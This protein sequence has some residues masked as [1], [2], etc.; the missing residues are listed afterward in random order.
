MREVDEG[1]GWWVMRR[2]FVFVVGG[3][4]YARDPFSFVR[5]FAE[6]FLMK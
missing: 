5:K 3:R 4:A 6:G 1:K 2:C